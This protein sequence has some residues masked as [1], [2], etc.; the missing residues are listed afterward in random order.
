MKDLHN[1]RVVGDRVLYFGSRNVVLS[2][3]ITSIDDD[4]YLIKDDIAKVNYK[5]HSRQLLTIKD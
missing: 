3:V 4:T 1:K 5:I 2:G